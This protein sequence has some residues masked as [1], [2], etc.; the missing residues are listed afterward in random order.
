MTAAGVQEREEVFYTIPLQGRRR[1]SVGGYLAA[2]G[3]EGVGEVTTVP[4]EVP[5]MPAPKIQSKVADDDS[6]KRRRPKNFQFKGK[7]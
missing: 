4:C 5:R 1:H 7:Y 6:M 2:G 3:L